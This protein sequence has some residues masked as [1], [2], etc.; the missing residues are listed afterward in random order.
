MAEPAGCPEPL[1]LLHRRPRDWGPV[2]EPVLRLS[3]TAHDRS[4]LRGLRQSLCGRALLLQL[5]REQPLQPGEWLLADHPAAPSV[6]VEAAPEAVMVVRAERPLALLQ[7]AYHLGNRHVA[8]QVE[9]DRLIL[10]A[11][12]VL[13]DLLLHRGL[14]LEQALA[15]FLPEGGAYGH[16]HG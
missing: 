15:P 8:L 5:P 4:R 10:L 12:P 3:L 14:Q 16:S 1:V 13:A 6:Q 9:A 2:G 7:A 11:D